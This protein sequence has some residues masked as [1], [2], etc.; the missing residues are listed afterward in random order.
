MS[1]FAEALTPDEVAEI[2]SQL[3][4]GSSSSSNLPP[5]LSDGRKPSNKLIIKYEDLLLFRELDVPLM[6]FWVNVTN[7]EF[8]GL[9]A[10]TKVSKWLN[11][12]YTAE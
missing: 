4:L 8:K 9:V 1:V 10:A 11:Q 7:G 2:E 6:D 12:G 3:G 5:L